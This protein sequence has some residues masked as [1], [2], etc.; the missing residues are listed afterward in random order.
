MVR[1]RPPRVRSGRD[2]P[3]DPHEKPS[4]LGAADTPVAMNGESRHHPRHRPLRQDPDLGVG[5]ILDGMR[6][7]HPGG[8]ETEGR[9]LSDGGTLELLRGDEYP[10]QTAGLEVDDVVHTARRA[11]P[12]IGEGLDDRLTLVGDQ[13][14]EVDR[15]R[16]GVSG[17]GIASNPHPP[18]LE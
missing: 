6:H 3:G 16:L 9:R 12:S 4:G 18:R 8:L 14:A 7:Q 10:R 2:L 5:P 15:G 11:T 17:L 13:G 1:I